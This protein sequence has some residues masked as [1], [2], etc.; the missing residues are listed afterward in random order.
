MPLIKIVANIALTTHIQISFTM[1]YLHRSYAQ[2]SWEELTKHRGWQIYAETYL[3]FNMS[4]QY[5][6]IKFE[7][8]AN[9]YEYAQ[10]N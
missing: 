4:Q 2:T 5:N 8:I 9:M 10:H 1:K 3:I 6:Q 7:T